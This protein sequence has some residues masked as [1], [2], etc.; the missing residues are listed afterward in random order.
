V[1]SKAEGVLR[2]YRQRLDL[3]KSATHVLDDAKHLEK[4]VR[5]IDRGNK[6]TAVVRDGA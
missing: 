2:G 6:K 1:F 5:Q 3:E 4:V